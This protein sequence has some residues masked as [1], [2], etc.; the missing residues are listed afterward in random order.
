[1]AKVK[2]T[3][4]SAYEFQREYRNLVTQYEEEGATTSDAQG[5]ADA[6]LLI[7]YGVTELD[8]MRRNLREWVKAYDTLESEGV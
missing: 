6:D 4:I 2:D 3:L 8:L 7:K 1:M 5:A